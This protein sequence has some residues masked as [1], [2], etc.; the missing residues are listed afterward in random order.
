MGLLQNRAI[1]SSPRKLFNY[2]QDERDWETTTCLGNIWAQFTA[3]YFYRQRINYNLTY[4]LINFNTRNF[5]IYYYN[6]C[7][8]AKFKTTC[9]S[10]NGEINPGKEIAKDNSGKWVHKHC[11]TEAVELP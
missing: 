7:M 10:C 4:G 1:M 3:D 2:R 5:I 9:I 6:E 11:L 8:K